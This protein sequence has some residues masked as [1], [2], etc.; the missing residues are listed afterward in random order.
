MYLLLILHFF[1][2][3]SPLFGDLNIQNEQVQISFNLW[4]GETWFAKKNIPHRQKWFLKNY[5]TKLVIYWIQMLDYLKSKIVLRKAIG[6]IHI[7]I[8]ICIVGIRHTCLTYNSLSTAK[9]KKRGFRGRHYGLNK[10][11][12]HSQP[13]LPQLFSNI[14]FSM[15]AISSLVKEQKVGRSSLSKSIF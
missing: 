8:H 10:K 14:W 1:R 13:F 12:L 11:K 7:H 15:D 4:L 5:L 2:I 6:H 3:R 9:V